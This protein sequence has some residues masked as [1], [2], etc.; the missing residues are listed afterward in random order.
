MI[1]NFNVNDVSWNAPIHQLN[2]DVLRRHVLINGKVDCLDLNFTYCEATEKGII[3]DS[4]N[5]QIG[6]FSIID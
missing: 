2:G 1:I 4:K 5:Q 6:H 3:T